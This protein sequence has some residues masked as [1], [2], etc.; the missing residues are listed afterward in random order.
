MRQAP[1][2]VVEE[3]ASSLRERAD[4]IE[5]DCVNDV[6]GDVQANDEL[7]VTQ[8]IE[9]RMKQS[10]RS[11]MF[12]YFCSLFVVVV[13]VCFIYTAQAYAKLSI[14]LSVEGEIHN[15]PETFTGKAT[16][17]FSGGG[18]LTLTTNQGVTCQGEYV[19]TDD[20][21]GN[22]TVVCEDGRL[23]SFNFVASGFS[24]N[25]EGLIDTKP[26]AFRIGK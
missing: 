13:F 4:H 19:N 23:G 21:Q 18:I 25:G 5:A 3:R 17:Y 11:L 24:G 15:T 12:P 16:A 10:H 8:S 6:A 22:G 14:N 20:N 1:F 7:L 2:T 26:F 9:E